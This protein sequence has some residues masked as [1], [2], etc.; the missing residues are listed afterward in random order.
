MT[1]TYKIGVIS[2]V[3]LHAGVCSLNLAHKESIR[4]VRTACARCWRKSLCATF[5]GLVPSTYLQM[6]ARPS[7]ASTELGSNAAFGEEFVHTTTR[8][9]E[10]HNDEGLL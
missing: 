6:Q 1:G 8:K 9:D 7:K 2:P 5:T 4:S 3:C 10:F